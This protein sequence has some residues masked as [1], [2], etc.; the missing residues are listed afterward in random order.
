ME[1]LANNYNKDSVA[2]ILVES[3]NELILKYELENKKISDKNSKEEFKSIQFNLE[4]YGNK[5]VK[6]KIISILSA[7]INLDYENNLKKL[8]DSILRMLSDNNQL[9]NKFIR[10]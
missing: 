2:Y 3:V 10:E 1:L 4:T 6:G 9:A 5:I 7:K 8:R